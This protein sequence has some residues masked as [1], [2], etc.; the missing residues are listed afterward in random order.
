M[1]AIIIE[2]EKR[3]QIYLQG[4]LEQI[5][6]EITVVA[7]CDDLPSGVIAIRKHNPD[8]VFL[9]IEMPK[10]SGLEIVNFFGAHEIQ[11]TIIFTTAYNQYAIQAFKTSA[12]D[13]LLKP[14]DPE[15]LTETINRY[16]QKNKIPQYEQLVSLNESLI[17][18]TK[19]AIPDGNMLQ[20]IPT[21]EII[22]L[23]ADSN[24][25]QV[26]LEN[27]KKHITSRILRNFE[28]TLKDYKQFFRC[29][30]SYIINT[31]FVECYSKS[32]GG[33][34]ILK[35]KQEIPVSPEKS[36]ELLSFFTK[37]ER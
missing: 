12:L 3:A 37:I 24:Y 15:E 8:L 9:D 18:E 30:K 27:G 16:K 29:H 5:A 20:L 28:E 26:F 21:E 6:P 23:K 22:Y 11:F 19:I 2:D 14:I 7:V 32:D 36:E 4:V 33:T 17:K 10:Y 31:K 35:N 25:T 1:K 34:I 13:Y